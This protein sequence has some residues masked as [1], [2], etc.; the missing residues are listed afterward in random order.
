VPAYWNLPISG[1]HFYPTITAIGIGVVARTARRANVVKFR[2]TNK[3]SAFVN[4]FI[5]G[6]FLLSILKLL[7]KD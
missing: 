4:E 1:R 3:L 6:D 2:K 5:G 7:L